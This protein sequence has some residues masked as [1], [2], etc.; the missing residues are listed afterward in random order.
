[1]Y[2]FLFFATT[3]VVNKDL[4]VGNVHSVARV[5]CHPCAVTAAAGE[6]YR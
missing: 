3:S 2:V 6:T 5:L 1:M 4:Y